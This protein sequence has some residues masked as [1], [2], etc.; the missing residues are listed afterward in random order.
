MEERFTKSL[1]VMAEIEQAKYQ[2]NP[3]LLT[4]FRAYGAKKKT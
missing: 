1:Q 3:E 2:Q 4:R